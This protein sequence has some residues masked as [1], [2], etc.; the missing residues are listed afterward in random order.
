MIQGLVFGQVQSEKGLYFFRRALETGR[1]R[2]IWARLTQRP[3]KLINLEKTLCCTWLQN[4]YFAGTQTIGIHSITGTEGKSDVFDAE[5]YPIKETSRDRWVGIARENLRGHTLPPVELLEVD[6]DYYVRDG[7][8][9]ISVARSL[10]QVFI[11]ANVTRV[12]L[13][14]ECK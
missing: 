8:H 3:T 13:D 14:C 1:R 2:R 4:S 9:R 7:H 5:F 11:E 6:G 12:V 10:G